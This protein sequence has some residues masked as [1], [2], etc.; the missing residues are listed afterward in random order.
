MLYHV[1]PKELKAFAIPT[2][3]YS[4]VLFSQLK[5]LNSLG[6]HEPD[7]LVRGLKLFVFL[8]CQLL[9]N[10]ELV[11]QSLCSLAMLASTMTVMRSLFS[12]VASPSRAFTLDPAITAFF[13]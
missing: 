9:L 4:V 3:E 2:K 8:H 1:L 10:L 12:F 6:G 11:R 7:L 13:S 5:G